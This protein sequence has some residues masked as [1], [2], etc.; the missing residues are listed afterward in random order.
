MNCHAGYFMGVAIVVQW[1]V[2]DI[3]YSMFIYA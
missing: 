2:I 3:V 1:D